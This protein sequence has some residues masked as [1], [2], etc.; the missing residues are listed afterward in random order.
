MSLASQVERG[1]LDPEEVEAL[2]QEYTAERRA[3]CGLDKPWWGRLL[4][5]L[6]M[7]V[8]FDLG[9]TGHYAGGSVYGAI[10][11]AIP[12]TLVLLVASMAISAPLGILLGAAR[13]RKAGTQGDL[14]SALISTASYAIPG[15]LL[16]YLVLAL[17]IR[18]WYGGNLYLGGFIST[19]GPRSIGNITPFFDLLYRWVLPVFSLTVPSLGF[20]Y[21]QSRSTLAT[22][23][24]QEYVTLAEAKGL[25]RAQVSRK[26]ILRVGLPTV[27]TQVGLVLH[28]TIANSVPV[29]AIFGWHGLGHL[30]WRVAWSGSI[31]T[32]G[33]SG[34]LLGVVYAYSLVY[35]VLRFSMEVFYVLLDPRIRY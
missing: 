9:Q 24:Q 35:A 20:W 1:Q 16:G 14:Y 31:D 8:T 34:L 27:L 5:T 11:E 13:A 30:L 22:V 29:E 33:N 17:F 18:L 15:W 10:A 7:V 25:S 12:Q 2:I 26:Y 3:E 32:Y 6:W 28:S 4:P 21:Y 23:A 19:T